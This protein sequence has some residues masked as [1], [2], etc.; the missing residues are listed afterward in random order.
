M[1]KTFIALFLAALKSAKNAGKKV[2]LVLVTDLLWNQAKKEIETYNLGEHVEAFLLEY[3][4]P[5]DTKDCVA[6]LDECDY[7]I[8]KFAAH[9]NPPRGM[10]SLK[11]AKQVYFMSATFDNYHMA[12]LKE[13]FQVSPIQ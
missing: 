11:Y 1:G 10:I 5:D 3:L 13:C 6:I 2:V 7:G 9:F 12:F 8:E 4:T